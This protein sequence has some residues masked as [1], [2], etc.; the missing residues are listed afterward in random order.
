MYPD[1]QHTQ[2]GDPENTATAYA[3]ISSSQYRDPGTQRDELDRFP[4]SEAENKRI[5]NWVTPLYRAAS[6]TKTLWRTWNERFTDE[7]RE[8]IRNVART[9][10]IF[11]AILYSSI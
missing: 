6:P 1:P 5:P 10:L 11:R 9:I 4:A 7:L 3:L 8:T 2:S